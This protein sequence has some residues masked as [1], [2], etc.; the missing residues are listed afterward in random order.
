MSL[1]STHNPALSRG[2]LD[3]SKLALACVL[4]LSWGVLLLWRSPLFWNALSPLTHKAQL[5]ELAGVYKVDPLLLASI[6]VAESSGDPSA[7]SSRGA[8]GLMQLLPSTAKQV[9]AE[10][11][12]NY[13]DRDD[14]YAAALNLRLGTDY[15]ARQLR[16]Q[17]GNLVLALAAYNAGPGKVRAWG[18]NPWA[19]DQ[20]ALIESIPLA[21]TRGYVRRVLGYYRTLRHMRDI[22]RALG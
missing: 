17:Q 9:A 21:E 2:W 19:A 3:R 18:L 15:F 5:Y 8:V 4:W 6:M 12:L 20:E 22:K 7:E 10:L 16:A 1:L 14:L 13:Q 11:R